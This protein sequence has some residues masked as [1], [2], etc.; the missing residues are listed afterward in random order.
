MTAARL[1]SPPAG[2]P[3]GRPQRPKVLLRLLRLALATGMQCTA[4]R[5]A[6]ADRVGLAWGNADWGGS[7]PAA[8]QTALDAAA[9]V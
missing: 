6:R 4:P 8:A 7:I 1:I 5:G 9:D 2:S 3:A